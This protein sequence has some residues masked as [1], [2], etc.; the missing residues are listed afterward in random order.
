MADVQ[1]EAVLRHK[2]REPPGAVAPALHTAENRQTG[3]P[4][5]GDG[6][7]A[8]HVGGFGVVQP[9]A[10]PEVRRPQHGGRTAQDRRTAGKRV[11]DG[12]L[13]ENVV[14][15]QIAEKVDAEPI[16]RDDRHVQHLRRRPCGHAQQ[17][18]R[19][20]GECR[21]FCKQPPAL[22]AAHGQQDEGADP[23]HMACP[24]HTRARQDHD[25]IE[26]RCGHSGWDIRE[27]AAERHV[28]IPLRP[29]QHQQ[30][31]RRGD[32]Q[33]PR[34]LGQKRLGAALVQRIPRARAADEEQ[35][36]HEPRVE[37]ILQR[38]LPGEVRHS[39][40]DARREGVVVHEKDV[41]EDDR[42]HRRPADVIEV[43]FSHI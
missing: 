39:P 36:D 30:P 23:Q 17:H 21:A 4:R 5:I 3:C 32:K 33:L 27:R 14:A 9:P 37:Q 8:V 13:R 16:H 41:V 31:Q 7:R 20:A 6:Q 28:E 43:V 38:I 12:L 11:H 35:H 10:A 2:C 40:R 22:D 15:G 18:D 42:Q 29:A 19:P 34:A 1:P 26:H 24:Q 25:E